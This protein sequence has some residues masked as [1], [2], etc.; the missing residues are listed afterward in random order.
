[1][2]KLIHLAEINKTKHFVYRNYDDYFSKHIKQYSFIQKIKIE[3]KNKYDIRVRNI[4]HHIYHPITIN[5]LLFYINLEKV[6]IILERKINIIMSN[7][8]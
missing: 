7:V 1:M 6:E 3:L 5:D 2:N 8:F 4:Y